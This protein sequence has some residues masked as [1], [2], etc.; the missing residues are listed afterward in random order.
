MLQWHQNEDQYQSSSAHQKR[1]KTDKKLSRS[2]WKKFKILQADHI[3]FK[4]K[5]KH[6]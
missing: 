1:R 2:Y 6:R 5:Q 3:V 4:P